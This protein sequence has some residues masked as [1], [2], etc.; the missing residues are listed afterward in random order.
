MAKLQGLGFIDLEDVRK[1]KEENFKVTEEYY[2]YFIPSLPLFTNKDYIY[3]NGSETF[4]I[5]LFYL[6]CTC[7]QNLIKEFGQRN[8][9]TI[10]SHILFKIE[11]TK[12][13]EYIDRLSLLLIRSKIK[14]GEEQLIRTEIKEK[15]VLFGFNKE[16]DWINTYIKQ[17]V[18]EWIRFSYNLNE[19]KWSYGIKPEDHKS[20]EIAINYLILQNKY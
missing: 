16:I 12:A 2:K 17:P 20:L 3:K 19:K 4:K 15:D 10:C 6:S 5:N 14:F 11:N 1:L 18:N 9:K 8:L 7:N 13:I